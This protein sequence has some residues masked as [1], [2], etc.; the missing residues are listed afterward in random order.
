[1]GAVA[2]FSLLFRVTIERRVP[3]RTVTPAVS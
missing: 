3:S 2:L 1:M